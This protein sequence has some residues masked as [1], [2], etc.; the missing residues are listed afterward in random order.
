M[1]SM[2]TCDS[3]SFQRPYESS[4]CN[5][6]HIRLCSERFCKEIM[7]RLR[8]DEIKL[9]ITAFSW[10]VYSFVQVSIGIDHVISDGVGA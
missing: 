8:Q 5:N 3:D 4:G 1:V 10:L 9:L 2:V 6:F 7:S